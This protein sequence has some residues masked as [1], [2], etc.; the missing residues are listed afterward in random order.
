MC[1]SIG[2]TRKYVL[3]KELAT[4][5]DGWLP[6]WKQNTPPLWWRFGFCLYF[7]CIEWSG[8]K[9]QDFAVIV[10]NG[11]HLTKHAAEGLGGQTR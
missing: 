7:Q 11:T 5:Q 3:A 9:W 8:Y 10:R 2:V 4:R 1:P 6:D